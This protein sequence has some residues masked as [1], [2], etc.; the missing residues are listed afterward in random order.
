MA[1][2]MTEPALE[3]RGL[4]ASH[5]YVC[6]R[7]GEARGLLPVLHHS[8]LVTSASEHHVSVC[9]C[10]GW[11]CSLAVEGAPSPLR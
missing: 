9:R 4:R 2:G 5:W 8:H 10:D 1:A 3:R 7:N 11:F 6:K